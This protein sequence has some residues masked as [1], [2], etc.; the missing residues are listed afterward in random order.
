M[1][2]FTNI[3]R[4]PLPKNIRRTVFESKPRREESRRSNGPNEIT[5]RQDFRESFLWRDV[6]INR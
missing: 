5:V 6:D 3:P 4:P 2:I 1:Y